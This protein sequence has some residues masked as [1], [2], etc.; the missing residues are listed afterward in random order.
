MKIAI[1]YDATLGSLSFSIIDTGPGLTKEQ[2]SRLFQAFSQADN[3]ITRKFGGSGLGLLISSQLAKKLNGEI[4][5]SSEPKKGSTF[6]LTLNIGSVANSELTFSLPKNSVQVS[7]KSDE[8]PMFQGRILVA[9]DGEDNQNLISFLLKK[10][11]VE[12]DIVANGALAVQESSENDFDIILLDMQ[13][14]IM[15]GYTAARQIRESGS[16]TPIVA[17]TANAMKADLERA[18]SMGCTDFLGKPFTRGELFSVIA[19]YL[20][21]VL[22]QTLSTPVGKREKIFGFVKED[23]K[24]L[25]IAL[26]MIE[27]LPL[28]YLGIVEAADNLEW[29]KLE[30]LAHELTRSNR[31]YWFRCY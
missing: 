28:R 21:Q 11:G 14:P 31:H 13:M 15:D 18:M 22:I 7:T 1:R 2:I 5:V 19:K 4:S 25:E 9:E 29:K 8:I 24:L 12:F 30:L 27:K 10:T 3:S 20:G 17:L 6:C 23:P 26:P 16:L